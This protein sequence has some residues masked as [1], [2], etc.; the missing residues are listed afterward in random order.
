MTLQDR[1]DYYD[2]L[3]AKGMPEVLAACMAAQVEDYGLSAKMLAENNL[4]IR[5][6]LCRFAIWQSTKEGHEFWSLL[7]QCLYFK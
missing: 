6:A 4:S 2:R 7:H 3:V 1:Q 5:E